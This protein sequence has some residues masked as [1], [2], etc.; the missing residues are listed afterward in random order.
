MA[1]L[2]SY[3]LEI[4]AAEQRRHLHGTLVELRSCVHDQFDMKKR[5]RER[6]GSVCALVSLVGLGLGYAVTGF[7]LGR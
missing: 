2:P 7:F 6:L 4:K 3:D 5:T 1:E